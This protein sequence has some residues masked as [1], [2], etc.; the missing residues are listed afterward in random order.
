VTPV[1]SNGERSVDVIE[2]GAGRATVL[3]HSSASGAR[4][5]QALTAALK[6]RRHV[7][8][9]NFMGYGDTSPWSAPR[10]QTIR[11]QAK[12]VLGVLKDIEGPIDLVGHSFGALIALEVATLLG[13]R[14]GRLVMHEPNPFAL[15]N[16]PGCEGP[17]AQAQALHARVKAHGMRGDWLGAAARFADFFSGPGAWAAMPEERRDALAASLLPNLHE[18]DAVMDPCL[19]LDRWEMLSAPALLVRARDTAA[20]LHSLVE[21]LLGAYPSWRGE[22]IPRGGHMAPLTRP[23]VFNAL[24][25]AFLDET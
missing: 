21:I 19:R 17:W 25:I 9:P 16:R 4:Q 2:Q 11:D 13:R 22:I 12:M 8:A 14:A 1:P 23:R 5:W 24:A 15:L 6:D 3:L 7:I 18:W 20:P 10:A